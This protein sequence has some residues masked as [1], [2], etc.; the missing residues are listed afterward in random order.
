MELGNW[1]IQRAFLLIALKR[2]FQ[3]SLMNYTKYLRLNI[4]CLLNSFL[5]CS[6][7]NR[8][9]LIDDDDGVTVGGND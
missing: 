1:V 6:V 7:H 2:G 4:H 3:D 9:F 8:G 5:F